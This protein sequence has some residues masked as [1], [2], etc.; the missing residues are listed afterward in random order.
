[1][2]EQVERSAGPLDY[3]KLVA[4]VAIVVGGL[5][6]FYVFETWPIWARWLLVLATLAAGGFVALQSAPGETFRQFV[7]SSRIELR[8]VVWRDKD[9]PSTVAVTGVVFVVVLVLSVFFAG[10]DWVLGALTSWLTGQGA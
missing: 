3:A 8:K 1:M 2:T 4:A 5:A 9:A 7:L 6:G 10:I